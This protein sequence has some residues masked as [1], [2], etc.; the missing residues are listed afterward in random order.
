MRYGGRLAG[1]AVD[2]RDARHV[3]VRALVVRRSA[4]LVAPPQLDAGPVLLELRYEL[5]R[6]LRSRA[7]GEHDVAAGACG[8]REPLR[9]DARSALG[10]VRD[11][12]L[13]VAPFGHGSGLL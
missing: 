2:Q 12:D 6:A 9:D 1:D 5:V 11:D 8:L 3:V 10:V 13:D 7:A 4:T